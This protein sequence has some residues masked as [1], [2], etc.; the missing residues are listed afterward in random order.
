MDI[1]F[2]LEQGVFNYRAAAILIKDHHVLL[3]KQ[4]DDKYWA[5]PGGR[6]ELMEDSSHCIKREMKEELGY[7]VEIEQL[8]WFTE[9]FFEYKGKPFHEI[10]LIYKVSTTDKVNVKSDFFYGKEGEHL[11]YKWVPI[12]ELNKIILYPE[13]LKT[14]LT[15]LP[16]VTQHLIIGK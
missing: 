12:E 7:E 3:H 1:T 10:G 5:L 8:I 16:T 15:E 13:F 4:K 2:Y 11:L 6:V 14:G 9:N